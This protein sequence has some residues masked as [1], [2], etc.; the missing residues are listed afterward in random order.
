[1]K[2]DANLEAS[3]QDIDVVMGNEYRW[4]VTLRGGMTST[5]HFY[6]QSLSSGNWLNPA[7]TWVVAKT[8]AASQTVLSFATF[9]NTFT[10]EDDSATD[11]TG[12]ATLRLLVELTSGS[13]ASYADDILVFGNPDFASIRDARDLP[14]DFQ[15]LWADVAALLKEATK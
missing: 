1:M 8:S 12:I 15:K 3:Y 13:A 4:S 2:L 7:S 6:I 14:A 5:I 10:V 9:G 11:E